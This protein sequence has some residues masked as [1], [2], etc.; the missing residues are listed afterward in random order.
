[1]R[2]CRLCGGFACDCHKTPK[3]TEK[4]YSVDII[5][6]CDLI[7]ARNRE[8]LEEKIN[9]YLDNLAKQED[10]SIT[11]GEVDWTIAEEAVK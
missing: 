1:M 6:K 5:L 7:S 10:E 8:H 3:P 11:W 9:A 4:L 2:P